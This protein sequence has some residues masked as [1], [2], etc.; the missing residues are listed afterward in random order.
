MNIVSTQLK[1]AYFQRPA[2][3]GDSTT[4]GPD[5]DPFKG[6]KHAI[7]ETVE[8][9][10]SFAKGAVPGYGAWN[11]SQRGFSAGWSGNGSNMR[12]GMAGAA[13]NGVG[14]LGLVVSAGQ[15]IFG[16]DPTIALGVSVAALA[17]GGIASAVMTARQ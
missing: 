14:T 13:L 8:L 15:Q 11:M 16:A 5:F 1:K 9:G 7:E 3:N 10:G 4:F 6:I 2:V 17:G 12:I